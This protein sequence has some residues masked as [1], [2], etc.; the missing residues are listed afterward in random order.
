MTKD[1]AKRSKLFWLATSLLLAFPILTSASD[2]NKATTKQEVQKIVIKL[3]HYTD[4]LHATTMALKLG[5]ILAT[6]KDVEV[7][8]FLNLEAVGLADQRVPQ[9]LHWGKSPTIEKLF[10]EATKSGMSVWVCP[11]CADAAGLKAS[12]LRKPA[13]IASEKDLASLFITADKV[14]DY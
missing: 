10:S 13:R 4:D 1:K 14:I 11:H 6:Q 9:D 12:N 8:L 2:S 5:K 3:G 7:S